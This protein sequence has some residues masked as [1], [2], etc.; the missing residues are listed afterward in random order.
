V[1]QR[2]YEL[3]KWKFFIVNTN[4]FGEVMALFFVLTVAANMKSSQFLSAF[5]APDQAPGSAGGV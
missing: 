2:N 1:W 5:E 3:P 4:Y